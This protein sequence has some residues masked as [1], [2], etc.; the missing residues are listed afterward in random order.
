MTTS[1]H[2]ILV[3]STNR[4]AENLMKCRYTISSH[5]RS[6]RFEMVNE[7]VMDFSKYFP[8][9]E[10]ERESFQFAEPRG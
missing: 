10:R 7:K 1:Y 4:A 9:R 5:W 3:T 8:F 6:T 2:L